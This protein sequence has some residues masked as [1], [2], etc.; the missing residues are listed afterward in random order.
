MSTDDGLAGHVELLLAAQTGR[1]A[2]APLTDTDDRLMVDDGYTIQAALVD[3]RV[4]GGDVVVGAKL[5]L[6]SKAKQ[7]AMGVDVP[8]YGVLLDSHRL[9]ADEPVRLDELI[10]PRAEPEIVFHLRDALAGPGV[11]VQ[12]VLEATGA[13]SC[14]LEII[15]SRYDGYRFTLTDLVA[16][17]TSA[18]KFVLGAQRV[19]P[20]EIPDLSLVGCLLEVD[21]EPVA[22]AAGAAV[23]GHP[24][25]AVALLANWLGPRGRAL[26]AGWSVLSGGLT[27]AVPLSV[28][29][30]VTATFGRLGHVSARAV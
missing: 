8:C 5:G 25:A 12:D 20:A 21:G 23:L 24:A 2:V 26:E 6:T 9:A 17:N 3:R 16:D 14:G 30:N 1:R 29:T 15:D 27:N 4:A 10:Q 19:D 22:T 13:L 11:T 28:G 18:G 7:Q